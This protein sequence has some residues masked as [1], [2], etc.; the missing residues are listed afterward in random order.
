MKKLKYLCALI[1]IGVVIGCKSKEEK[2]DFPKDLEL[3]NIQSTNDSICFS[4]V[5]Q[6]VVYHNFDEASLFAF[7]DQLLWAEIKEQFPEVGFIFYFSGKDQ[8][9]LDQELK[10]LKFPYPVFHDPNFDFYRKNKLDTINTKY[11]VQYAFHVRDEFYLNRA[12]IGMKEDFIKELKS[13]LMI[14]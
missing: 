8:Q 6:V 1:T 11:N 5:H 14:E 12:Q 13:K 10:E 3:L 7:S 9:K 4:C 2:M